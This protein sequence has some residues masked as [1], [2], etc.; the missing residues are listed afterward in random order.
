MCIR[1]RTKVDRFTA[2]FRHAFSDAVSIRNLTRWQRVHQYSQTSAPQGVFC[3][4][5][6][7][8][9]IGA[10]P[11]ATVGVPCPSGQDMAGNY[12][13][14]G[15]RGLVRDQLNELLY[16][17]TDLTIVSGTKGGVHNTLVIGGSLSQEDYSCLLYTSRCV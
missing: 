3:L 10:T 13:P 7:L 14:A 12:Y 9:P 17:Q 15:P 8:Q 16:N 1:D 6:G 2:T 4:A 11:D 5:S